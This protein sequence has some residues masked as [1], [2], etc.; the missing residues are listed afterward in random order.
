MQYTAKSI[1]V[2]G[3]TRQYLSS[4]HSLGGKWNGKLKER[5]ENGDETG[6]T[7]GGWIFPKTMQ[8]KV[9]RW[10]D[11]GEHLQEPDRERSPP[12]A[13]TN[14]NNNNTST[15]KNAEMKEVRMRLKNIETTQ[16]AIMELLQQLIVD[17]DE[18]DVESSSEE[19]SEDEEDK[20]NHGKLLK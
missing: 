14:N 19:E 12:S 15:L 16:T 5:D 4:F 18:T 1:V 3:E 10:M 7:Y 17:D 13:Y 20:N 2:T 8:D 9:Q 6:E 11:S